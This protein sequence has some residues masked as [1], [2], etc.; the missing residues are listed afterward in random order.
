[1]LLKDPITIPANSQNKFSFEC[2]DLLTRLLQINPD[3]RITFTELQTHP[4]TDLEKYRTCFSIRTEGENC[5]ANASNLSKIGNLSGAI[6]LYAEGARLLM[7]VVQLTDIEAEKNQL[8]NE[9]NF[10]TQKAERLKS[11]M[12]EKSENKVKVETSLPN[13]ADETSQM[14][15]INFGAD[16]E[17]IF[18]RGE[19]KF[20]E[21][22]SAFHAFDD[23]LLKQRE[24][25][26]SFLCPF[27]SKGHFD[28]CKNIL[29]K[30]IEFYRLRL[31]D[32]NE[33]DAESKKRRRLLSEEMMR[34][35]SLAE[36]I[37]ELKSERNLS[38]SFNAS[39]SQVIAKPAVVPLNGKSTDPL[40]SSPDESVF[41]EA[42]YPVDIKENNNDNRKCSIQ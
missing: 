34:I 22:Q 35:V 18:S 9:V 10:C 13:K 21:F 14:E 28:Q 25:Q 37:M 15:N 29:L 7:E 38:E 40:I 2:I 39:G 36:K 24:A 3:E 12:S 11:R 26:K 32:F 20:A 41:P 16:I 5:F 31:K 30:I 1:M 27:L 19:E 6:T 17:Q 33:H 42:V 8:R 23:I 4:F